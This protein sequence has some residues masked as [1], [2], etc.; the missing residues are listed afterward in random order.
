VTTKQRILI[1]LILVF[2]LTSLAFLPSSTSSRISYVDNGSRPLN[3]V[4]STDLNSPGYTDYVKISVEAHWITLNE[5]EGFFYSSQTVSGTPTSL[6]H[7]KDGEDH[8]GPVWV[9]GYHQNFGHRLGVIFVKGAWMVAWR[10]VGT[11]DVDCHTEVEIDE[12]WFPGFE[13]AHETLMG[14]QVMESTPPQEW[15]NR[16]F[17]FLA[18]QGTSSQAIVGPG[19]LPGAVYTVKLETYRVPKEPL[20]TSS[21]RS[22]VPRCQL[23]DVPVTIDLRNNPY[24][25]TEL[26]QADTVQG[27]VN[28]PSANAWT[29][30][31]V[32]GAEMYLPSLGID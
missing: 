22:F 25:P 30:T 13:S 7:S 27:Q 24:F 10:V 23:M 31:D 12:F 15:D 21:L 11:I 29:S 4:I 14:I 6:I 1:C 32:P 3:P 19:I 5:Y 2:A 18:N 17:T 9:H 28:W 8:F 26:P 16:V 20:G